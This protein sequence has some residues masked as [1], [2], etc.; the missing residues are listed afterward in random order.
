MKLFDP[1]CPHEIAE[2]TADRILRSRIALTLEEKAIS[3][4]DNYPYSLPEGSVEVRSQVWHFFRHVQQRFH[5]SS[6]PSEPLEAEAP[7]RVW[8]MLLDTNLRSAES[9]ALR[10]Y[11]HMFRR[12]PE[13][14]RSLFENARTYYEQIVQ[15]IETNRAELV[16]SYRTSI[17]RPSSL[18][19][20]VRKDLIWTY[21]KGQPVGPRPDNA[22]LI[23]RS[24]AQAVTQYLTQ[25]RDA[26]AHA[27]ANRDSR[28]TAP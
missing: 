7:Q 24:I 26:R 22:Q 2:V 18:L 6:K 13:G 16:A 8:R 25:D 4:A 11:L 1:A 15:Y 3:T 27:A 21:D 23:A 17:D 5:A 20:E 12:A 14:Q 10:S 28:F 19:I 9:D